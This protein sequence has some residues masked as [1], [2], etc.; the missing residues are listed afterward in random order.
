LRIP[1]YL[2]ERRPE[3]VSTESRLRKRGDVIVMASLVRAFQPLAG[4]LAAAE[5]RLSD[6]VKALP[7]AVLESNN[8]KPLVEM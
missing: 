6:Q 2:S 7:A 3:D 5:P 4:R 1:E 8:P